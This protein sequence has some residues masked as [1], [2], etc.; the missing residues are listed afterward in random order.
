MKITPPEIETYVAKHCYPESPLLQELVKT[1]YARTEYP[2]MLVGRIEG[3]LLRILTQSIQ[4]KRVIEVGTFTG[5]SALCFAESLPDDGKVVTCDIDPENTKIAREYW[6]K[7][8]HGRKIE[9]KLGPASETIPKLTGSFDLAFIDADKVNYPV[10]FN[11][12][13]D[14]IRKG[15]LIIID[16][17]LWGGSVIESDPDEDTSAI[18]KVSKTVAEDPRFQTAMLSV[19]DGMLV[20]LKK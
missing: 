1:T 11:L 2:Q 7:S 18:M 6:E 8:P 4:A 10:Y 19:R 20:A 13:A 3:A 14:K 9:L 5:Y 16:N 15:G 12:L 17:V